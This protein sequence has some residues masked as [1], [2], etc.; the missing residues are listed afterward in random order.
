VIAQKQ[1]YILAHEQARSRAMEAVRT[2]PEG[3]AV[4]IGPATR[5]LDQN[6]ALWAMLTDISVQVVWH[7]RKL[8]NESWKHIF[9]SSL[10]KQ[11]VVPNLD[12]T[13][14]VVMG[15]STSKMTKHEMSELL[16]LISAFGAQ[17]G[18]MWSDE[19]RAVA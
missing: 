5:S 2:A 6:A 3:W 13:G 15:I 19:S 12:G 18:V 16:E 1:L 17:H 7:G 11:D 14:F 9:S 10:K 8:D 4:R